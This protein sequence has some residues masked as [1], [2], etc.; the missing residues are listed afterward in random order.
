MSKINISNFWRD[1]ENQDSAIKQFEKC[2]V[3]YSD[4]D[5]FEKYY[6]KSLIFH[7]ISFFFIIYSIGGCILILQNRNNFEI[8][9]FSKVLIIIYSFSSVISILNT[10][11]SNVSNLNK[12]KQKLY[13]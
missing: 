9:K 12:I 10:Y 1:A 3:F 2:S 13:L 7:I 4:T 11:L 5:S 6:D 8:L